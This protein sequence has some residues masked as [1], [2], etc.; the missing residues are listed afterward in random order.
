MCILKRWQS[1]YT[2]QL[3]N[4]FQKDSNRGKGVEV[5]TSGKGRTVC[6]REIWPKITFLQIK[7]VDIETKSHSFTI[8]A[9]DFMQ[10]RIC[11]GREKE[12]E[13]EIVEDEAKID[14]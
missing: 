13:E 2:L 3:K 8:E 4:C 6:E 1:K 9:S 14:K 10:K 5:S 11:K 7:F 12:E